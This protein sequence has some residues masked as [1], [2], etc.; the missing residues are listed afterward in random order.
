M[1]RWLMI[2]ML[3]VTM[4]CV[5][6][7][8][9]EELDPAATASPTAPTS[10]LKPVTAV[11]TLQATATLPP[12]TTPVVIPTDAPPEPTGTPQPTITPTLPP[13]EPPPG[14]IFF[15]L[16]PEGQD[17][18]NLYRANAPDHA[19]E[20]Q[21][22]TIL[23][24]ISPPLVPIQISPDKSKLAFLLTHDT[25][26][27]GELTWHP[28]RDHQDIFVYDLTKDSIRQLTNTQTSEGE[29][30]GIVWAL[31]SRAVISIYFHQ[32][33]N[34]LLDGSLSETILSFADIAAEGGVTLSPDGELLIFSTTGSAIDEGVFQGGGKLQAFVPNSGSLTM[35]HDKGVNLAIGQNAWSPDGKWWTYNDPSGDIL[36]LDREKMEVFYL[37]TGEAI[38]G[39]PHWSM[40]GN[41]LAFK[42]DQGSL[43]L[44]N[45]DTQIKTEFLNADFVND[46]L[47]S[48]YS[49]YHLAATLVQEDIE[50][51]I[52]FDVATGNIYTHLEAMPEQD[53]DLYG[54]S[55]DGDW[56]LLSITDPTQSGLFVMHLDSGAMAQVIDTTG[57]ILVNAHI[58]VPDL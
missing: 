20:W 29:S 42:S 5:G 50:Q 51:L 3:L 57:G 58:W 4:F 37:V 16:Q 32:I 2:W 21:I 8:T 28:I 40:D 35:I 30:G 36:M 54:W 46:P 55:P 52:T 47:W 27:D 45:P 41:W 24:Q 25:N 56:L 17:A 22:T 7:V 38:G 26:G 19:A 9:Q 34:I 23:E 14:E 31:D 18:F 12:T 10:A 48:P 13:L 33:E 43:S 53:F 11:A 6:C 49:N 15:F 39:N 1:K 44:W